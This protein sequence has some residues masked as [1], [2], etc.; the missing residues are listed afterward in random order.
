M[1][2]KFF[3]IISIIIILVIFPLLKPGYIFWLDQVLN[4]NWWIPKWWDNIFLVWIFSQAFIFLWIPVWVLEK[5]LILITFILPIFWGYLLSKDTK[6]IYSI[7]FCS[8]LLVFNPFLYWRFIDW[9]INIYLSYAFY[10]IFFYFLKQSFENSNFKNVFFVWFIS[11]I[12]CLTSLHNAIFLFFIFVVFSLFHIRKVWIKNISKIWISVIILNLLWVIPFFIETTWNKWDLVNQL[13]YFWE[14]H[15]SVFSTFK[16][17]NLYFNVLSLNWYWGEAEKRFMTVPEQNIIWFLIFLFIF[18]LVV[19]SVFQK[20]KNKEFSEFDKAFLVFSFLAFIFGLWISNANIFSFINNLMYDYFP[21]YNWM[22][23]PHK[24]IM[25]LVFCYAYFWAIWMEKIF[26]KVE[27]SGLDNFNKMLVMGFLTVLPIFYVHKTLFGFFWQISIEN[28]PVQWQEAKAIYQELE[29]PKSCKYLESNQIEKCYNA[30]VFP[31][32]SYINIKFTKKNIWIWVVT[33]F[34]D[35]ILHWDNVEIWDI[36]SQSVR[37]ESKIIEK[38]IWPEGKLRSGLKENILK[39]FY[40]DLSWL[41]IK[42]TFIL[43]E[44]DYEPYK[45]VFDSMEKYWLARI[46]LKNDMLI[47]YELK[48]E[49]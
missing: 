37:P 40:K 45:K 25:F 9:Q 23:E 39:E 4:P 2:N 1:K 44:S 3:I 46:K 8:L 18:A 20:I 41:W 13:E 12:L 11:L 31:W 43:L 22:R 36:Y 28:Y 29:A 7:L 21:M 32:H 16:W 49:N 48:P 15:R 14:N 34:W 26:L 10:P 6:N 47:I 5:I 35:N 42:Y 33:Y 17:E 30:L 27:K 24:W 38:Y 19:Y